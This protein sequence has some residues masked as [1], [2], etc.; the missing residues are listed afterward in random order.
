MYLLNLCYGS[1]SDTHTPSSTTDANSPTDI[2]DFPINAIG[3]AESPA[4]RPLLTSPSWVSI[5]TLYTTSSSTSSTFEH[6][7]ISITE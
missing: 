5:A 4:N 6:D 3:L 2:D 7:S 1:D